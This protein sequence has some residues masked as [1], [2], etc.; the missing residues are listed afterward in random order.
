MLVFRCAQ[1]VVGFILAPV[2]HVRGTATCVND[3][4]VFALDRVASASWPAQLLAIVAHAVAL[5]G[6]LAEV[7]VLPT[8]LI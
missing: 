4:A 5:K 8:R 7:V 2:D 3:Q 1:G 6:A